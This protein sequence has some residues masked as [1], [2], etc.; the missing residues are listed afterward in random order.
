MRY[1]YSV[2]IQQWRKHAPLVN[3]SKYLLCTFLA[4]KALK[5]LSYPFNKVVFECTLDDLVEEI[6]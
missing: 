1:L 5:V 3:I 6:W 2:L 4:M